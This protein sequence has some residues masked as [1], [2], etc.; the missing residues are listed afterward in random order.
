MLKSV[1]Q[2]LRFAARQLSRHPGLTAV[3]VLTL[4][5]GIGANS[6]IFSLINAVLF[7]APDV[8]DPGRLVEIWHRPDQHKRGPGRARPLSYPDYVYYRDHNHVFSGLMAFSGERQN[9]TWS[10][11]GD[12]EIIHATQVT[13]NYFSVLGL[14]PALGRFFDADTGDRDAR[15]QAVLGYAFW[16]QQ[17]GA[18]P[19]VIGQT[20]DLN[21]SS[22]EIV[23]VAPQHFSGML[24]GAV[25]DLWVPVLTASNGSN[26]GSTALSERRIS[27]LMAVGRLRPGVTPTGAQAELTVLSEQLARSYPAT[28][29][30]LEAR[31]FDA[32]L[33]PG[34]FRGM[35]SGFAGILLAVV[36]L[37]LLIA[38]A[39][40]ANLLLA[41][42]ARRRREMAVRA[43]LGAGRA[44]LIAQMLTEGMLIALLAGGVGLLFGWRMTPL[45]LRLQPPILDLRFDVSPDLHLLIFT[46]GLAILTGILFSLPPAFQSSRVRLNRQLQEN[47][48]GAGTRSR[49]QKALVVVQVA[50]CVVVLTGAG[51]CL[52]SLW[53]ATHVNPG[54]DP[55]H[56]V[57]A[58]LN[59]TAAGY[60]EVQARHFDQRL[61]SQLS[62]QPGVESVALT[63]NLPLS[64]RSIDASIPRPGQS[65]VSP[66]DQILAGLISA[67]PGYFR[68]MGTVML[69]GRDFTSRDTDGAP[70]VAIVDRELA[71]R[72]WP[73]ANPLGRTM[74]AQIGPATQTFTIIG[75]VQTGKYQT[76]NE[77]PKP[78]FFRPLAQSYQADHFVVVRTHGP[79]DAMLMPLRNAIHGLDA[80]LA[81]HQL[82]TMNSFMKLPLFPLRI[83]G[84]LLGAFGVLALLLAVVGLYGVIAWSVIHR[85]REIG[86][87]M[88]L[89]AAP[90][91]MVRM[92]LAQGLRLT[93]PGLAIGGLLALATS[94]ALSSLLFGIGPDD[95]LTFA[96]VMMMLLITAGVASWLP[97][98]RAARTDPS[99]TLRYE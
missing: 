23:G 66:Q 72:L 60:T 8:S 28:N 17:L 47:S 96:A 1:R 34:P 83:A 14:H 35:L 42:A 54:F 79:A 2:D 22:V 74:T 40:A 46:L 6:T 3:M 32:T 4:A 75:V 41:Q 68:T 76:L 30:D 50:V 49:L 70:P 20:I 85:T 93:L 59:L 61:L 39:N 98:R 51:L 10:R 24:A 21:G 62:A 82:E 84:M 92:V 97:A 43:A 90:A 78:F 65:A 69:A 12:A 81:F 57:I 58:D 88:A 71:H 36:G 19:G 26:P 45:L 33:L 29:R 89:G 86:L 25:P 56:T 18:D 15:R 73:G 27:W 67:S 44:R 11:R 99:V 87:R 53:M 91:A 80:R 37:V 52:R 95:P 64:P 13:G 55:S 38:C 77:A 31:I 16:E 7:R 63:D 9:L 48:A 5:L 94:H